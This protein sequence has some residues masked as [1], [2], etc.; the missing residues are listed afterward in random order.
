VYC[1]QREFSENRRVKTFLLF[2]RLAFW[3]PVISMRRDS[4][5]GEK[6]LLKPA[7]DNALQPTPSGFVVKTFGWL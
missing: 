3:H 7:A 6:R 2:K 5:I 1:L 4:T